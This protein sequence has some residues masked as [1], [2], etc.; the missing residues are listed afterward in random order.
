MLDVGGNRRKGLRVHTYVSFIII[1]CSPAASPYSEAP[2]TDVKLQCA[3]RRQVANRCPDSDTVPA[4]SGV[5]TDPNA[6]RG[7]TVISP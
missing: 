4:R 1:V 6:V 7:S 3:S 2:L 5:T